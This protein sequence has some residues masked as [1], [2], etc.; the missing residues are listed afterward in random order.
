MTDGT[1]SPDEKPQDSR[2]FLRNVLG[3][4]IKTLRGVNRKEQ[5]EEGGDDGAGSEQQAR[6]QRPGATDEDV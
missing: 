2:G 1:C 3:E 6:E 4:E 5:P